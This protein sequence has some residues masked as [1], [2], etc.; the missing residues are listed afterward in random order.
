MIPVLNQVIS[1]RSTVLQ[2]RA[3]DITNGALCSCRSFIIVLKRLYKAT[4]T[5]YVLIIDNI[6]VSYND[7]LYGRHV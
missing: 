2:S 5:R 1:I 3:R 6:E 4:L 7:F